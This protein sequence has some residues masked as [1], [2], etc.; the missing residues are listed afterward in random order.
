[1]HLQLDMRSVLQVQGMQRVLVMLIQRILHSML[2][3]HHGLLAVDMRHALVMLQR[4]DMQLTL[5]QLLKQFMLR[6]PHMLVLLIM[7]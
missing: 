5:V 4:P 1:M 6:V 2:V 3:Q 7:R